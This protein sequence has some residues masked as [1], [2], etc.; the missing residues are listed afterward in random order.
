MSML[1]RI[2]IETLEDGVVIK[3][4]TET[5]STF[6]AAMSILCETSIGLERAVAE[7]LDVIT[8]GMADQCESPDDAERVK[9]FVGIC[10]RLFDAIGEQ[11]LLITDNLKHM[12]A[13]ADG[14]CA[15]YQQE[16]GQS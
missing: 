16:Q 2:T 12:K 5:A 8:D 4:R 15:E 13:M 10:E 14:V 7:F 11:D 6:L 3:A 9:R 1:N